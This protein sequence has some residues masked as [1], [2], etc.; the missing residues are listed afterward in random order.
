M[1]CY[2]SATYVFQ[3]QSRVIIGLG[4]QYRECLLFSVQFNFKFPKSLGLSVSMQS[5]LIYYIILCMKV[6]CSFILLKVLL[7]ISVF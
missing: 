4:V 6:R 5:M 7:Y 1:F 2:T 3:S